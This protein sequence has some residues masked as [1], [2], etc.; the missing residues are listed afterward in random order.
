MFDEDLDFIKLVPIAPAIIN[1]MKEE[2]RAKFEIVVKELKHFVL[3]KSAEK[4]EET[5]Q[6]KK[7]TDKVRAASNAKCEEK[8][9]AFYHQKKEVFYILYR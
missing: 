8:L 6:I 5:N 7:S 9:N 3:K 4:E 2:F 1:D